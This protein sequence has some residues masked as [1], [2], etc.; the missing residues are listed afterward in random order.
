M[1]SEASLKESLDNLQKTTIFAP[2]DGIISKLNVEKG[3]RVVGT[4]QMS[5]TEMMSIVNLNEMEVRVEVSENDILRVSMKD[6][7]DIE[8]DAYLNR[9]F[10]GVVTEIASSA[11][12]SNQ[13][14]TDQVTNFTVKIKMLK[15]SYKDLIKNTDTHTYPFRS[16]MSASVDI[17]TNIEENILSVPIQSVTTREEKEEKEKNK[18]SNKSEEVEI[19]VFVYEKGKAIS[20]KVTTGIQDDAFIQIIEGLNETDEVISAP[21]S[22]ISRKLK[23]GDPVE[24]TDIDKLF[25]DDNK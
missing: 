9:K 13:I 4:W 11:N 22:A 1:S 19:I 21:Y 18:T 2:S 16:G 7:A 6:T 17:Q 14:T 12:T 24:K 25:G 5:G 8:V 20:K 10:K 23:N 3:E 15:K